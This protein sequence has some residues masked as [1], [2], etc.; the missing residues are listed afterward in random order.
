ML[1]PLVM[2]NKSIA[3]N[4]CLWLS[5]Y[6][7]NVS[8]AHQFLKACIHY[9][10]V[11]I[12]LQSESLSFQSTYLHTFPLCVSPPCAPLRAVTTQQKCTHSHFFL[13]I[14][15]TDINN[16]HI[17]FSGSLKHTYVYICMQTH[18]CI[19]SHTHTETSIDIACSCIFSDTHSAIR[20]PSGES[21]YKARVIVRSPLKGLPII[22]VSAGNHLQ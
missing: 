2:S 6:F 21:V 17:T 5:C 7:L 16:V 9:E 18:A 12:I 10:V 15:W 14:L 4:K 1:K 20:E 3:C 8:T 11:I 13:Q 19:S 22:L